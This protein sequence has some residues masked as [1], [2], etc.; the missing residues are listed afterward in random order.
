MNEIIKM[1]AE[2]FEVFSADIVQI[3]QILQCLP[4]GSLNLRYEAQ[5]T[6]QSHIPN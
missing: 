3:I 6:V 1:H 2:M 5:H 4:L